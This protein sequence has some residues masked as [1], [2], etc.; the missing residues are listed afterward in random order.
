MDS[1][2]VDKEIS[3]NDEENTIEKEV[4]GEDISLK[5]QKNNKPSPKLYKRKKKA[6]SESSYIKIISIIII[7][8]L[9]ILLTIAFYFQ[10]LYSQNFSN[11]KHNFNLRNNFSNKTINKDN[12]ISTTN[13]N[14]ISST[15]EIN[16]NLNIPKVDLIDE[17]NETIIDDIKNLDVKPLGDAINTLS[18]KIAGENTTRKIGIAFPYNSIYANG[19]GRFITVTSKYLIKTGKYDIFFFTEK[20]TYKEFS[21]EPEIKR[22]YA[23]NNYTQMRNIS[24]YYKIDIVVL[25]NV[26]GPSVVKFHHNL[27]QKVICMFHGV[28]MS[29]MYGGH[30]TSYKNWHQFDVCDSFIFIAAD[31]YYFYKNLG[32]KNAI[33]V[34]NL[35]T[36]D[37]H[38]IASSNLTNHNI[39][40]LGRLNDFIKGVKYAIQAMP[41]ILKEVPD[42]KLC[43][44]SCDSRVQFLKNMTRDLNLTNSIIFRGETYKLTDLFYNSSVHMYTSLSEAFPMALVEGKAHGMPV[45]GFLV[46]YSNP[47]QQGFIG[48]DLFD[49]EGLARETIKLLKDYDY[50]KKMGEI[51]KKSLDVFKNNETVELW[52][53]LCDSLLSND[54]ED[55]R[56]LQNEIEKKYYN[57]TRAREHLESHYNILLRNNFNLTCHSFDNFTN[58]EYLKNITKCNVTNFTTNNNNTKIN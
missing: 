11:I 15:E 4:E 10:I 1:I 50:R 37:P 33:F 42:A 26:L 34:P 49:V 21:Y 13:N 54:R 45:V 36:Y 16:N 3:S 20:P 31:D 48:V 55:Y 7:F 12:N 35:Y 9:F 23:F 22:F 5:P 43:L 57:E 14:N 28:F 38:E 53:R 24:K 52:G 25:Q 6:N 29:P 2:N 51:A 8:I 19:I 58:L 32:Y 17:K 30:V 46:P 40:I 56:K 27:G 39:V 47:Y 44:V 18:D 41:Y